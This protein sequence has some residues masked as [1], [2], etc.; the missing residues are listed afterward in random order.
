MTPP[1][2]GNAE[3]APRA[4]RRFLVALA[5]LGLLLL[6]GFWL[7]GRESTLQAL[8]QKI[9]D[10]SGGKVAV[11]GV[12]GSLYGKMHIGHIRYSSPQ[13]II[14]ADQI[15]VKW[16]PLQFFSKG[17][18]ISELHAAGLMF[19]SLGPPQAALL[20]SSLAPPFQLGISDARIDRLTLRS[21]G[22]DNVL[23]T[24]RFTLSGDQSGWRL[25][26]ASAAT[27]WGLLA[28][29]ARIA[30]QRPF[31]L[32]ATA[33]LTQEAPPAGQLAARLAARMSGNLSLF[34]LNATGTSTH[35]NGAALLTLAPFDPVM[36][37]A[38][39]LDGRGIDPSRFN[40]IWPQADLRLDVVAGIGPQ[41]T[42]S[43]RLALSNQ[44][45]A[46][47]LD[48]Q[49]LPLRGMSGQLAGTLA[50]PRIDAMQIDL[51]AAGKL[52]GTGNIERSGPQAAPGRAGFTLHTERID[53]KAI[54]GR[55]NTTKIAGDIK[56]GSDGK[57]HTLG[58][59][60]ADGRLRL[61]LRA[62]LI[63]ELLQLQQ[64]RLAAGKGSLNVTG[65]LS[66][67]DA[68]AFTAAA[69]AAH[70]NPADFGAYPAA[71]LNADAR[72]DGHLTPAWQVGAELGLRPSTLFGQPLSGTGKLTAD[73]RHFSG[74]QASLALGRNTAELRGNFGAP[75]EQLAWRLNARQLSALRTDLTGAVTASG[76][77]DGTMAAPRSS[78]QA[79][80]TG[81]GMKA[82]RRV[83]LDSVLQASF[84][85]TLSGPS[86]AIEIR[87]L[88]A[89]ARHFSPAAFGPYPAGDINAAIQG[90]ARLGSDWR[91]ALDLALQGSTLAGA[92]LSGHANI[93]ADPA[94]IARADLGLWLGPN[95][96]EAHGAF[97]A[98]RDRV[99][100]KIEAPQVASLGAGFG[101]VLRGSGVLAGSPAAPSLSLALDGHDLR[102]FG[103]HQ[104]KT[105]R[106]SA[107]VGAGRGGADPLVSDIELGGYSTPGLSLAHARLQTS[108][109]RAAHTLQLVARDD[110]F[111][112]TAR[113]T[114]GWNAGA[115][116][117][118]LELLQNRG[119][120]AFALQAPVPLRLAGPAGSGWS[121]LLHP[122]QIALSNAVLKAGGGTVSVQSLEKTG[123]RWRS[124][125]QAAGVP[126]AYLAQLAPQW[127]DNAS[128]DLALGAQWSLDL[129][130]APRGGAAKLAGMLHAYREKGDLIA[131]SERPLALG[132]RTLDARID[133][134]DNALRLRVELDGARIGQ[135]RLDAS[136][137]M[138]GGR[139]AGNSPLSLTGNINMNS[140][141][142]LGPLTGQAG[143]ELDGALQ[144]ALT[145]TG[146]IDNPVLAGDISAQKLQLN[147]A[148]HGIKLRNGQLQARLAG[149]QL[150]LTRLA[151]DGIEG[152]A[153]AEG[154]LR[155]VNAEATMELRL[156][157]DK[158]RLLSRPDRI[159]VV[160]GQ[161]LLVRDQ[162]RVR[163]EGQFKA[164]R[165]RIELAAKDAPTLSDDIVVLGKT[166]TKPA[167]PSLP[168][169]I[170][171]Q[172]DLGA[173]F[174]LKGKGLDAQ[175]GGSVR[176]RMAER[177]APRA[178]GSIRVVSGTYDAYGQ[179]L[180]IERGLINFS[181]AYDNPGLNILAVRKRPEGMAL[182]E[183]NVEAGV[184]VHGTA[185]SPVARLVS[186]PPVPDSEKLA[187]LVLGHGTE[188]TTGN[189]LGLLT[190]A[191]GALF[192]G[193]RGGSLQ[194]RLASS[195][196]L[197]ELGL[198]QAKGLE[199]TVVTVGKRI[200]Q[201]AYLSF[202]QGAGT[203]SSLVKVRYK[204]NSR[205]T[206]QFQTGT[207][208]ALDVLYTWAFD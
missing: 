125:G 50:A 44:G 146:S 191:A 138:A 174:Y 122:E 60:L 108:G 41:Q 200:T 33:S 186:T 65:Q 159:L 100:W 13:R 24:L 101:G 190:T 54:H 4:P 77:L 73:A 181:G 156:T 47:P 68:Q 192:G 80:A 197:D 93:A 14:T 62:T 139:V 74:V 199:S 187:W 15:D 78:F 133:A 142:W 98:P 165:A 64:A 136:T 112:T 149:N 126:L 95:N 34:D 137:Q 83:P 201:R 196:G 116:N 36:L 208:T 9:A 105:L 169:N 2:P 102:L 131:G 20:P 185:L 57:T 7:L 140:L 162:K 115:W 42:I 153:Q 157:A 155:F 161:G 10:A 132:L 172:A 5:A 90:S 67:K 168:L 48:Q 11:S 151:F 109:T 92:P 183:T 31:A 202:E 29:D 158:L 198:S 110:A 53:L 154:W 170:D 114:G 84:D 111:D 175:L 8:V 39:R 43:G 130:A 23:A 164:D 94:H 72:L 147:W 204:L 106:A 99:D 32:D 176:I 38:L 55:M 184:E 6:A 148:E 152:R 188:G 70:F 22:G 123:P 194:G 182:S 27:P 17:I 180:E 85:A 16:S 26:E 87:R 66:L 120:F 51:G 118:M 193:P 195:L 113:V 86:R 35:A 141:A 189:E 145:G 206:L 30:A 177:G 143:L 119:R 1:S 163:L 178:T 25:G 21:A 203:A 104:L 88:N 46:G 128:G 56:L 97:G 121:G 75:G 150:Q 134:L 160:S 81:L 96:I 173:A 171:L 76:V 103:Q 37:R 124:T 135:A 207:N 107:S 144:M 49:R 40:P 18:A 127:R 12:S 52:S 179:K 82:A 167:P 166:G 205:I 71:D 61:D 79:Q 63:N 91:V 89:S 69:S 19:E 58:A 28:A 129:Q 117:G 45:P 59:L 3:A